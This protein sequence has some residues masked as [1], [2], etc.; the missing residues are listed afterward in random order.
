M[1]RERS[2]GTVPEGDH[3]RAVLEAAIA[4]VPALLRV[5]GCAVLLAG[6][7]RPTL[8]VVA[9]RNLSEP[10]GHALAEL[11][12]QPDVAALLAA[13]RP[14][15]AR[16]GEGLPAAFAT[17]LQ[18]EGWPDLIAVPLPGTGRPVGALVAVPDGDGRWSPARVE[19]VMRLGALLAA[20]LRAA[21]RAT[22]GE[23]RRREAT[24]L[25]QRLPLLRSEAADPESA[26]ATVVTGVGQALGASHC[27]GLLITPGGP[28]A[29]FCQP[30]QTPL[31]APRE[32]QRHPLWRTLERGGIWTYDEGEAPAAD[33]SA[34]ARMLADRRPRALLAAPVRRDGALL[35]MLLV[36]QAE[37][38]RR[39]TEDEQQF[40]T[41]AAAEL[42]TAAGESRPTAAAI[43]PALVDASQLA[44]VQATIAAAHDAASIVRLLA[45]AL[46]D[47]AGATAVLLAAFD[48]TARRL[49]A[50]AGIADGAPLPA[51]EL[52]P[53]AL[54]DDL[55]SEALRDDR[56]LRGAGPHTLPRPW[57]RA[58]RAPRNAHGLVVPARGGAKEHIAV[59]VIGPDEAQLARA[60]PFV[61]VLAV[62]AGVSLAYASLAE[63]S[64]RRARHLAALNE[65]VQAMTAAAD[66]ATACREASAAIA[67][68]LPGVDLVTIWLLDETGAE[69]ERVSTFGDAVPVELLAE[70]LPLTPAAGAARAVRDATTT[71]WQSGD[72]R[73]PELAQALLT[74]FTLA[75]LASVPMRT[76]ER[77]IGALNLGSRVRRAYDPDELRFLDAL[78]GQLGGHLAL[79]RARER[80]EAQRAR[81][82][83][84]LATL[85]EGILVVDTTPAIVLSNAAAETILGE[86]LDGRALA[87]LLRSLPLLHLDGRP[88]A[89]DDLPLV[90]ALRGELITGAQV[91]VAR[92]DGSEVPLLVN[93]GPVR[94]A[95]GAISGAVAVFQDATPRRALTVLQD[96]FVNT[97]SH[98]LRTPIT[99]IRGGALTLLKRRGLLDEQTQA[100]LLSDIAEEADRLHALVEDLLALT[101]S[102][103][104]I[105]I[106]PE[107][108]VLRRLVDRVI[109]EL[110]G[111]VGGRPLL[112]TV[113]PDLPPVETDPALTQQVVR[114]LLENAVKFSPRGEPVE[115]T[116]TTQDGQVVV[117]V[118]DRGSGIR[119]EDMDRVFEPFFRTDESVRSGAQGAGLGLAVCRRLVEMQGG[120]V[121]AEPR[122][123]GGAAFRFTLP[124]ARADD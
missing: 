31:G 17:R 18:A 101:R 49:R 76:L 80:A 59:V 118:L 23:R 40:I 30:G 52:P 77:V 122:P 19:A 13:G 109:V 50:V 121:W 10:Q 64:Q 9:R 7:E 113:P 104:G 114:N 56:P 16:T 55:A 84:L 45:E 98:E 6:A 3:S 78:A 102:R 81:L 74:R 2:A 88:V 111:R 14:L 39:F 33:R 92:A 46:R 8:R 44:A 22:E 12:N 107:P 103:R 99:T 90:R 21:V 86:P 27:L 66:V 48:P 108:V 116:A 20:A 37:R 96:E 63:Q 91:Q 112:V 36:V 97:V 73:T 94:D 62:Q 75:T 1:V 15:L 41:A 60:T 68:A 61:R 70:R 11:L 82:A 106:S 4:A 38:R 58:Y 115:V 71:V 25:L 47:V 67:R 93:A 32:P 65:V 79:I 85:P 57:R 83:S 89:W 53:V 34:T 120:R 100:D 124:I 5:E 28:F 105:H 69:L 72:P 123:G 35:G 119:P 54:G 95:Q 87:D 43:Q 24:S 51:A 117:S 42:A 26:L 29:E 110:G